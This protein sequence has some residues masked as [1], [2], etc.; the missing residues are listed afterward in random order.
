MIM[1]LFDLDAAHLL[2]EKIRFGTSTWTYPGWKGLIYNKEYK[3][4]ASFKR[5]SLAEYATFP[6]FRTVG[7]DSFFYSPPSS[8]TLQ[9]YVSQ[10]PPTFKWASKVW[11]E[12]TVPRYPVHPRYGSKRGQ[13]NPTFLNSELFTAKVIAQFRSPKVQQHTGPFIFQFPHIAVSEMGREEF[14]N[15]LHAFLSSLP[16]DFQYA[17]EVRNEEYLSSEYFKLLNDVGVTHCFNH[18]SYM[19]SLRQQ[20]KYAAQAGGL[21]AP[22]LVMRI[23]TP[24]GTN[25]SEAVEMFAPYN[26]LKAINEEMRRDCLVFLS[27]AIARG[28][29]T[30]ILVNNRAEGCAPLTIDQ[31]GRRAVAALES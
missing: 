21:S 11:E 14:L 4:E 13:I 31:I 29:E 5:N 27:R 12:I 2:P 7:V 20:M 1:S 16:S 3:S 25:Y 9:H 17:V 26:E 6:W 23:L 19:P 15:R 10:L 24:L 30:F 8:A 18:W 22:F 28:D